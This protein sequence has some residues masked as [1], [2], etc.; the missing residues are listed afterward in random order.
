MRQNVRRCAL[1][2]T[3]PG[4]AAI[5]FEV[6]DACGA[7]SPR[8]S[9]AG[10][11]AVGVGSIS[12]RGRFAVKRRP[13]RKSLSFSERLFQDLPAE[14]L[15]V[16]AEFVKQAVLHLVHRAER[17]ILAK[18]GSRESSP[19]PGW[20][21]QRASCDSGITRIGRLGVASGARRQESVRRR[22]TDPS[23]ESFPPGWPE[24]RVLPQ[25]QNGAEFDRIVYQPPP[26]T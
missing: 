4:S 6:R 21:N 8:K 14:P 11:G 24:P 13:R 7:R 12:N 1:G 16:R 10:S 15:Q 18:A 22:I 20:R 19:P 26:E 23:N 25:S 17:E 2:L 9:G 5:F 3:S